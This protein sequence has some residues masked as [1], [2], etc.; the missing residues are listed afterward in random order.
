MSGGQMR[1]D[2]PRTSWSWLVI[3]AGQVSLALLESNLPAPF[4]DHVFRNKVDGAR[5][6]KALRSEEPPRLEPT[7]PE[8]DFGNAPTLPD[9]EASAEN[10]SFV[11][12]DVASATVN[13]VVVAWPWRQV[14]LPR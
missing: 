7:I 14:S 9:D 13:G 6:L 11:P 5:V 3:V 10:E 1:R 4:S 8:G 2:R 12:L